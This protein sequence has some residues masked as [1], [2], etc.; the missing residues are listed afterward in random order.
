MKYILIV[1]D[2]A[3]DEP[4]PELDQRTPLQ[5]ARTPNLDRLAESGRVGAVQVTPLDMYPGSDAANMA[6][7]G[8]DPSRYYTGRGPIEAAAMQ[9]P[10]EPRDVAFRC[11]LVSTDGTTLL[12]YSAGHITTEEARPL[13]E[14]AD[15]KLG[16][17]T[18]RLFPGV[19]YRHIL[20]WTDGPVDLQ[21]HPPHENM[22]KPLD[23]IY[24]H[25]D[26]EERLRQFIE[27]SVNLLD[28]HPFNKR[29]RDEGKP[30]ANMLWPW[31]PGRA[32][33]LPSFFQKHGLTGAVIAAVDVIRGLGRL[34]GLEIVDVPGATGYFDTNYEGK[35][36]YAVNALQRH[37]FV[38]V[39]IEAPDEAGHAGSIDEKIRAIENIDRLVVGTILDGM[40]HVDDFRLLCV[41][42][43]ATPIR[44][45]GHVIG[46]VPYL[47]YDS[48]RHLRTGGILPF[49]ER[50]VQEASSIFPE[51]YRLIGELFAS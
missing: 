7:L 49:D 15:E 6:L 33:Q 23:A 47:L 37:D 30:P 14:L 21:T 18:M 32:P 11:S 1:P 48:R 35:G 3:A 42:D 38:W 34:A 41:P 44:T 25:G 36:R 17:H 43:H 22:G 12:D 27:D 40:R 24:P 45:R 46:P 19:S 28:D 5:A 51:G 20:R 8:Y 50:A 13:I 29:R 31:S 26:G 39:H 10:M 2:G 16:T 4:L 9:I